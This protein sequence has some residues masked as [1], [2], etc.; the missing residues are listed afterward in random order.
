MFLIFELQGEGDMNSLINI[1]NIEGVVPAGQGCTLYLVGGR[2]LTCK[3]SFKDIKRLL[4]EHGVFS[5]PVEEFNPPAPSVKAKKPKGRVKGE[6]V[7][8]ATV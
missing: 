7:T 6:S 8:E 5:D 2:I 4:S 3:D 1:N